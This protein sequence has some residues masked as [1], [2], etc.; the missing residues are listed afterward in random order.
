M[1]KWLL[2]WRGA[3]SPNL[4]GGNQWEAMLNQGIIIKNLQKDKSNYFAK[5]IHT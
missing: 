4:W 3:D 2:L 1:G 5:F